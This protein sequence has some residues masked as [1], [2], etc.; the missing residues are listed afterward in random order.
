MELRS[1]TAFELCV[2][3]CVE[4]IDPLDPYPQPKAF[5]ILMDGERD[6]IHIQEKTQHYETDNEHIDD[7]IHSHRVCYFGII[8]SR[9]SAQQKLPAEDTHSIRMYILLHIIIKFG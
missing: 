2:C 5:G 1:T 6:E 8:V 3:V 4:T 9:I 7:G